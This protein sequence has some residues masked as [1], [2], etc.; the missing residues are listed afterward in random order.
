MA[1]FGKLEFNDDIENDKTDNVVI[2]KPTMNLYNEKDNDNTIKNKSND[3]NNAT[4]IKQRSFQ[5]TLLLVAKSIHANA[6]NFFPKYIFFL[7][8]EIDIKYF[9][10][11][12]I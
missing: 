2:K 1:I 6:K 9:G 3:L 8:F 12:K 5:K 7:I 11:Q 4:I 10:Y